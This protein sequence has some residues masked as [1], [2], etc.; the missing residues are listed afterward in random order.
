MEERKLW[1]LQIEWKEMING[2]PGLGLTIEAE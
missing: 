2:S 1:E